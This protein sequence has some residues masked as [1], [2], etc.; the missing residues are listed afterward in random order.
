MDLIKAQS[1]SQFELLQM[2]K[3]QCLSAAASIQKICLF[4][5]ELTK[6]FAAAAIRN[7]VLV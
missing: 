4:V 2:R 7:R 1:I 5:M 3:R 6:R